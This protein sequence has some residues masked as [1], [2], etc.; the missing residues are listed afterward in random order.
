M[1]RHILTFSLLLFSVGGLI[2]QEEEF[3]LPEVIP[4]SPTVANMMQFEEVPIDFHTGQPNISIPVFTKQVAKGLTLNL[5]LNYATQ[6]IKVNGYSGWTGTSWSMPIG[7]T[8]SRTVRGLPDEYQHPVNGPGVGT[9]IFHN[10]DFWNY[11]N[12][13]FEDQARF[14]W[15]VLGTSIEKFDADID[16]YQFSFPGG[17]GRFV[18]TKVGGAIVPKLISKDQLVKIEIVQYNT[19]TYE[20]SSFRITDKNGYR[21][22]FD[23]VEVSDAEPR[24]FSVP[25]RGEGQLHASGH[26]GDYQ[27]N[28]AWHLSKV[29]T[30]NEQELMTIQYSSSVENYPASRNETTNELISPFGNDMLENSYNQSVFKPELTISAFQLTTSTQKPELVEFRDGTRLMLTH[31]NSSHPETGGSVLSMIQVN[32]R[33]NNPKKTISFE[34]STINGRLWLDKVIH[35]AD[36]EPLVYSLKYQTRSQLPAHT[37]I[38][39]MG[40]TNE[41]GYFVPGRFQNEQSGLLEQIVFPSGGVQ[42]FIFEPHIVEFIGSSPV[43]ESEANDSPSNT[44]PRTKLID[45][46]G[47]YSPGTDGLLL[48]FF[49][50]ELSHSQDITIDLVNL[51][52]TTQGGG[53][54]SGGGSSQDALYNMRLVLYDKHSNEVGTVQLNQTTSTVPDIPEG[55]LSGKIFTFSQGVHEINGS[56]RFSYV[57]LIN[58]G[59]NTITAGGFRI[60]EVQFKDSEHTSEIARRFQYLYAEGALDG[61]T[62]LLARKDEVRATRYIFGTADNN[63]SSFSP[64][65][66]DYLV[67][68]VNTANVNITKGGHVGYGQVTV[69]EPGNG[70]TVYN[71]T[72]A[73]NYPSPREV[74]EHPYPPAPELDHQRGLLVSQKVYDQEDRILTEVTNDYNF[75][76]LETIVNSLR[77]SDLENCPWSPFYD[78]YDGYLAKS[79]SNGRI[80]T[81]GKGPCILTPNNCGTI[82]SH[83]FARNEPVQFGW[84][85]KISTTSK[86]YFYNAIGEATEV[87][88]SEHFSYNP[89]NYQIASHEKKFFEGGAEVILKT[90]FDYPTGVFPPSEEA[91]NA[92]IDQ[93]RITLPLSI[94]SFKNGQPL[95]EI[96]NVYQNFVLESGQVTEIG[97]IKSAYQ[98]YPMDT[99]LQFTAY[100]ALGNVEEVAKSDDVRIVYLWGYGGT[101]PVARIINANSDVVDT[102]IDQELLNDPANENA[103]RLELDKLRSSQIIPTRSLIT[104]YTYDP[105]MGITS[106]TDENG[107]T[108]Y[109]SY[110]DHSRLQQVKDFEGNVLQE[111]QYQFSTNN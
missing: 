11:E 49:V 47:T 78:T 52:A 81:C 21:Y 86:S 90:E 71:F 39:T 18:V 59:V 92:L 77:V 63:G 87:I 72:T 12:L 97:E 94:L 100:N 38:S 54:F 4:P 96:S 82:P 65:N 8:I 13:S 5:A 53:G 64:R 75:T 95:S 26:L 60:S 41:W 24:T 93:N 15:S 68:S 51:T 88:T 30:Y 98:N 102:V 2:A 6:G 3:N 73:R 7:G 56:V 84:A 27:Y 29:E 83:I 105:M 36:G 67:T 10:D 50:D 31:T 79:P 69:M 111:Y 76:A 70:Y 45:V 40:P 19:E 14:N 91:V 74:F 108:T 32:D 17:S 48:E 16:L 25:F 37:G 35:E 103:L 34:Y 109:F 28:S 20:I 23:K 85:E 110:D 33:E 80:P 62:G 43:S 104:T 58:A 55:A 57:E 101:L 106:S 89:T 99:R 61:A 66:I 44:E 1:L 9:G 22:L 42:N 107:I 46:S